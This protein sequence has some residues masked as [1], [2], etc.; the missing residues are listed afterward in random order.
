MILII[1]IFS[2][3]NNIVLFDF[4]TNENYSK[5]LKLLL[6][7]HKNNNYYYFNLF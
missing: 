3:Y 7:F 6:L 5:L 2:Y 4:R 1:S